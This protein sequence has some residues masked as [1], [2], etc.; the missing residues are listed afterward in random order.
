MLAGLIK[1]P[2]FYSP[3]KEPERARK[4]RDLVL[5]RMRDRRDAERQDS[6]RRCPSPSTRSSRDASKPASSIRVDARRRVLPRR[7]RARAAPALRLGGGLHR[8]LR[9]YTTLDRRL[10]RWPK[11]D[12]D[13]LARH[14]RADRDPLQ[15]AL[16]AIDPRTGFV[17]A[18]VG[19]RDF[20]ESP[21]N[22]AI[23]ARRQPGSAFK[24]FIYAMALESGYSPGSRLDGLDQPIPTA[25]GPWLPGGEH[26]TESVRCAR[27]SSL[28]SNRAAAHLLQE[29][30]IHRTL[31]LV[32]RFGVSSPM[33]AVPS[34]A[35]GTGEM[36]LFELTSAY[37]VFANRGMWQEPTMIRRV[38]DRYGR[39]IYRAP[40]TERPVISEATAYMMT[41]MM[42]DVLDHG[43]AA[44]ARAAASAAGRGQDRHVASDYTDA[45]F[46]GYTPKLVTGVWF[47]YDKPQP[48][49]NRGFASV[50]AVPAWARF[51]T[52]ALRGVKSEWFEMPGSLVKVKICRLS[53]MLATDQ[54][55]L[56]VLE[57][58]PVDPTFPDRAA[59][60]GVAR[61]RGLRRAPPRVAVPGAVPPCS[62]RF[63]T[64]VADDARR[65]RRARRRVIRRCL[66]PSRLHLRPTRLR[67]GL[68]GD[69]PTGGH[70]RGA[71]NPTSSA[72]QRLSAKGPGGRGTGAEGTRK[73]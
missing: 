9:V 20:R 35:L 32:Q 58:A 60:D 33:P 55:H 25:Q 36:T 37:G 42:S 21:F 68:P 46:V 26:E 50:V 34:V 19:G 3:T 24:P 49:M 16:V 31:D 10:Q 52:A 43:T 1:G 18:I 56:P 54:C 23:D 66:G 67:P 39:E 8:R 11:A 59:R 4:R 63:P 70:L 48:I 12:R 15:G 44:T 5:A 47:G 6:R 65:D 57:S 41:S 40:D 69:R 45:W 7:R 72:G 64:P 28:S 38:V 30:G 53:G 27:R 51:M 22:R 73:N 14:R 61:G 62:R 17:K 29:V 13:R 2:S 71:P